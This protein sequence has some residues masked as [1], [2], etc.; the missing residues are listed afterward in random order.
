[1]RSALLIIFV[2]VAAC[3]PAQVSDIYI[4]TQGDN[5]IVC[6]NDGAGNFICDTI[7]DMGL[8]ST[9]LV[10]EDFNGDAIQDIFR[11]SF[12]QPVEYCTINPMGELNCTD[13]DVGSAVTY[14]VDALDGDMDGDQDVIFAVGFSNNI[15]CENVDG[16]NFNCTEIDDNGFT[17]L[18]VISVDVD[19][20]GDEDAIFAGRGN[21]DLQPNTICYSDGAGNFDC[22]PL[23][24]D[25]AISASV[26]ASDFNGDEMIDIVF[27]NDGVNQVCFQNSPGDFVCENI[28]LSSNKDSRTV[29]VGDFDGDGSPDLLFGNSGN[30]TNRIC[31]NDGFGNFVCTDFQPES[32]RNT[33][34]VATED[35]D[36]DGDLDVVVLN[37]NFP[38][39]LAINDGL[40]N[41]TFSDLFSF[42][43]ANVNEIGF[44]QLGD[45]IASADEPRQP[46]YSLYPNPTDG[47]VQIDLPSGI[48]PG[49]LEVYDLNGLMVDKLNILQNQIDLRNLPSGI[50]LI[51]LLGADGISLGTS[52]I[53]KTN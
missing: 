44:I 11:T 18:D 21:S 3:L 17:E 23:T 42:Q 6:L 34:D 39:Q 45:I 5:D 28:D 37:F 32:Q 48:L 26:D 15:Y 30:E 24:D 2:L 29:A 19:K 49:R 1:M 36:G 35:V 12:G 52:R 7:T 47:L 14:A 41:F 40:G 8:L 31:F 51:R 13:L 46:T 43:G 25:L 22:Q 16:V 20:D 50:Y 4:V 53:L 9:A 38:A 27:A 10:V 33:T